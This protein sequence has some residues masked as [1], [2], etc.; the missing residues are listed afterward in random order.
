[1]PGAHHP[2]PAEGRIVRLPARVRWF[3]FW[4]PGLG[5][6]W[7]NS[8]HGWCGRLSNP[9]QMKSLKRVTT[10][11][12]PMPNRLLIHFSNVQLLAKLFP[13]HNYRSGVISWR[14]TARSSR[15]PTTASARPATPTVA[16]ARAPS[17]SDRLRR[18]VQKSRLGMNGRPTRLVSRSLLR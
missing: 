3:W 17:R 15:R 5:R 11:P 8:R 12:V 9:T 7:A 14:R 6:R 1:V 18:L 4:L 2:S 10:I 16:P 13:P